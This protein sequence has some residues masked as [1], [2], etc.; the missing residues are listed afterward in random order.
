M[1]NNTRGTSLVAEVGE[2]HKDSPFLQLRAISLLC[3]YINP[4]AMEI[5]IS[6][7]VFPQQNSRR[8]P[9]KKNQSSTRPGVQNASPFSAIYFTSLLS[10]RMKQEIK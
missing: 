5:F 6:S 10:L 4:L 1:R 8:A 2:G 7:L 9:N 3:L